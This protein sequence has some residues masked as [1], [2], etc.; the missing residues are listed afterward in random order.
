MAIVPKDFYNATLMQIKVKQR[1]CVKADVVLASHFC[2]SPTTCIVFSL[3]IFPVLRATATSGSDGCHRG[4]CHLCSLWRLTVVSSLRCWGIFSLL[5]SLEM[6]RSDAEVASTLKLLCSDVA[7]AASDWF[8]WLL[9][10]SRHA[11]N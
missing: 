2:P 9:N 4:S 3:L 5:Q 7:S 1:R 6:K 8:Q 11:N 10:L